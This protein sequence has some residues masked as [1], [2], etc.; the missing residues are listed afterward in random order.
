MLSRAARSRAP[1]RAL[2]AIAIA[3][4]AHT[5]VGRAQTAS[6]ATL[7]MAPTGMRARQ[8][9]TLFTQTPMKPSVARWFIASTVDFGY[10]FFRPRF[11]AGFG[12]PFNTWGGLEASPSGS[13][14]FAAGYAGL[15]VATPYVNVR[16]GISYTVSFARSFLPIAESYTRADAERNVSGH[17]AK[18]TATSTEVDLTRKKFFSDFFRLK[19]VEC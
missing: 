2:L 5:S 4:C 19:L 13:D 14:T 16:T 18:S 10:L 3:I 6:G 15:R 1:Y 12:Q 8:A 9:T 17:A 11:G 7:P